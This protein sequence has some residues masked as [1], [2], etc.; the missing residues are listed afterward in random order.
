MHREERG[1]MK[2]KTGGFSLIEVL[3]Y[4]VVFGLFLLLTA[5][6]FLAI[7]LTSANS[8]GMVSLQ[9]NYLRIF[10]DL[11]QTIRAADAVNL[12]LPGNTAASLSLDSGTISYQLNQGVLEK[13]VNGTAMDLSDAGVTITAVSFTNVGAADQLPTIKMQINIESNYLLGGGATLSEELA[14]T[15]GLR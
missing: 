13:V 11:N 1:I 14:T 4:G 15:V 9:E 10:S 8:L 6:V 3:V 12:P 2:N 7:R 5:Q